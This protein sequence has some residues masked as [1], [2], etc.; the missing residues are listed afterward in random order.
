METINRI[1]E[2]LYFPSIIVLLILCFTVSAINAEEIITKDQKDQSFYLS[3]AGPAA[4]GTP[5][6]GPAAPGT[7]T[8][9]VRFYK[10]NNYKGKRKMVN[11]NNGHVPLSPEI[12]SLKLKGVSS[13]AV[14]SGYNY[15]GN[16]QVFTSDQP[17]LSLTS[18]GDNTIK[19]VKINGN[20]KCSGPYMFLFENNNYTGRRF[21]LTKGA[22]NL[23]SKN[24]GHMND[25]VSSIK[26]FNMDSAALYRNT[27]Y[28]G[29]CYTMKSHIPQMASTT[30]NDN[31]LSSIRFKSEC[32]DGEKERY[33]KIR[34]NAAAVVKFS[35]QTNDPLWSGKSFTL[36]VGQTKTIKYKFGTKID[37]TIYY[38]Y[39]VPD[40]AS[41]L[42][43]FDEKCSFSFRLKDNHFIVAKGTLIK[44]SCDNIIIPSF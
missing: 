10:N 5:S 28:T 39:P 7:P 24:N 29:Q 18:I 14:F 26:M 42:I 35:W 13:V 19:S 33:L 34:N 37:I 25:K 6:L 20:C 31:K 9:G 27:N 44:A 43:E 8:F 32:E 4:P 16:C 1:K 21:R 41:N 30:V 40:T 2:N 15:N 22:S 17:N 23:S 11:S 3:A 36:A 38:G 12:S